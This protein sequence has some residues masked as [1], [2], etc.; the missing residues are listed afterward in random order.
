[1]ETLKAVDVS[2]G[3]WK[4]NWVNQSD[5]SLI[6]LNTM[7]RFD[8]NSQVNTTLCRYELW[9][10]NVIA[11]TEVEDFRLRLYK[12]SEMDEILRKQGFTIEQKWDAESYLRKEV[13]DSTE[14]IVYECS[15]H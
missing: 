11:R 3:T 8:T 6:V 12:D 10:E 15:K 14:V 4:G 2:Q 5:G 1:M 13:S 9:K 7:S